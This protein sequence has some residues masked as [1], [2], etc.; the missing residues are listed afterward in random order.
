M[1]PGGCRC[2]SCWVGC[3]GLSA[4]GMMR[5][6][7]WHGHIKKLYILVVLTDGRTRR[8]NVPFWQHSVLLN[9]Q[10]LHW[11]TDSQTKHTRFPGIFCSCVQRSCKK[12]EAQ[13]AYSSTFC[14]TYMRK[15]GDVGEKWGMVFISARY[16]KG[17]YTY[18]G[19][20]YFYSAINTGGVS[21]VAIKP[22]IFLLAVQHAVLSRK[23]P[24]NDSKAIVNE[25]DVWKNK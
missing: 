20:D 12:W 11:N 19:V 23:V 9:S 7:S 16:L 22:I 3:R 13:F 17:H 2:R 18:R 15:F 1:V 5:W 10:S 8:R 21:G 4:V 24:T 14:L 6:S 25:I